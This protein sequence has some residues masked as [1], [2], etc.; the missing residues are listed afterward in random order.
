[1]LA[2]AAAF[3]GSGALVG[4]AA[5]ALALIALQGCGL[6]RRNSLFLYEVPSRE[7][8]DA[9]LDRLRVEGELRVSCFD[10]IGRAHV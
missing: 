2:S 5:A 9:V 1:M 4:A 7:A 3:V 10:E 6:N 8:L